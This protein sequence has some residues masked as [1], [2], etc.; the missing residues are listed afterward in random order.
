MYV[1]GT[2]EIM[3]AS[4]TL[5]LSEHKLIGKGKSLLLVEIQNCFY[6]LLECFVERNNVKEIHNF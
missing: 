2:Q 6:S 1:E 3:E 5:H 4:K